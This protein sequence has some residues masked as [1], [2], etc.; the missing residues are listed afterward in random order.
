MDTLIK[1][2]GGLTILYFILNWIADNPSVINGMRTTVNT[3]VTEI[4]NSAER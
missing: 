1:Y 2:V 4:T 3:T